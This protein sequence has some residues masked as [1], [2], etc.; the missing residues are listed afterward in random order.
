MVVN[1]TVIL[2]PNLSIV[3]QE[4]KIQSINTNMGSITDLDSLL[5]DYNST[6]TK[7]YRINDINDLLVTFKQGEEVLID[8][9]LTN[10]NI[11]RIINN[12]C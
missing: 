8:I 3:M 9:Q 4:G 11:N 12:P 2:N 1:Q 5:A 7:G 6:V 10:E